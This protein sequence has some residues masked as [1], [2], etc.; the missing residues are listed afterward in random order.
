[1][2]Q[3]I[4]RRTRKITDCVALITGGASVPGLATAKQQDAQGAKVV[5]LDLLS[6]AGET[7]AKELVTASSSLPRTST[8]RPT[9]PKSWPLST[10]PSSSAHSGSS[11]TAPG[12]ATRSRPSEVGRVPARR[13]HPD[14][15]RQLDRH[16]QRDPRRGRAHRPYRADRR[17]AWAS[18]STRRQWRRSTARWVKPP[19]RGRRAGSSA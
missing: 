6:S 9:R 15:Y 14:S 2:S 11:S 8:T 19:P 16:V 7:V 4:G 1:M 18:S 3:W 13:L 5:L 12:L 10:P 17:R